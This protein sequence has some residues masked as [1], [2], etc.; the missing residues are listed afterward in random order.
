MQE[1]IDQNPAFADKAHIA[2]TE[3]LFI[4]HQPG[5]PNFNN[6]GGAI[7]TAGFFNMLMRNSSIVPISDMTGIMEFSG[8]WK[9]RSQVYAAPGYYAF[10]MYSTADAS[11]PVAVETDAGSYSVQH[12]VGRIPDISHVPYLDVV[13]ALND[14]GDALTL[15]CVN[16]SL[17]TD[18]P[19]TIHVSGF[20]AASQAE[21]QTLRGSSIGDANDEDD[22]ERVVPVKTEDHVSTDGVHHVFPHE[23]VTVLVLHRS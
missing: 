3:W 16:R 6:M 14:K 12:G 9:K 13:A 8:I 4:G 21:V 18:I 10:R 7:D 17:D 15:F 20:S 22:P 2:F 11:R 19:A 1:Q 23:S 5:T